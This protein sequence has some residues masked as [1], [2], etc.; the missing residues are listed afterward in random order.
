MP[1]YFYDKQIRRYILQFARIFSNFYVTKGVDPD[2]NPI[3]TRIP[4]R[5]G[6]ASRQA[7]TII[8]ENSA[9]KIPNAPMLTYYITG[10][11]YDRQRV[12]EPMF[13]DK[14][15]IRQRTFNNQTQQYEK[16]QQDAF[17]V[18]RIMP[19]P[20]L[21]RMNLDLWTTSTDQKLEFIEQVGVLFNPALDIQAND[22]IT[23]WGSLTT[24]FQEGPNF[25]SRS[26]PQGTGN[27]ID[28]LTWR[29]YMPIWLSSPAKLKKMGIIHKIIASIFNGNELSDITDDNLFNGSRQR[30]TPYGYKILL[31]NNQLQLLPQSQPFYPN[32]ALD[33][34]TSPDTAI[35]WQGFLEAHGAIVEGISQIRIEHPNL[36]TEIVGTIRFNQNDGRLLHYDIDIDTLPNDTLNPVDKVIDPTVS[37]PGGNL[38]SELNGQRYLIIEDLIPNTIGWNVSSIIPTNSII[39]YQTDKWVQVFDPKTTEVQFVTTLSSNLQYMFSNGEWQR[40]IEGFYDSGSFSIVI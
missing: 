20:Y 9:N 5:Y 14:M 13:V 7:S 40:S 31:L 30:I 35:V 4:I 32:E 2:N 11:E 33:R 27:P 34:P 10:F 38:P 17:T 29:F 23:D 26:V 12:Q 1:A 18:E 6:D 8:Q 3:L 36:D 15:H 28:I 39:E 22:A 21:L 16:T 19:V 25:T 24:V 37:K